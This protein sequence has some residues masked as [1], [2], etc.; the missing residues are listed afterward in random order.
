MQN[1]K[2][3]A[4]SERWYLKNCNERKMLFNNYSGVTYTVSEFL[5]QFLARCDGTLT[6][7]ELVSEYER[8]EDI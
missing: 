5:Y 1:E 8:N 4:L 2:K 3:V 7:K 6:L